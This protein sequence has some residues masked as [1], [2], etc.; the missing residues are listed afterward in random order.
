MKKI[1][2]R[3][4]KDTRGVVMMEYIVLGLFAV[5]VTVAT[6]MVLGQQYNKGLA[7]MGYAVVGET[8]ATAELVTEAKKSISLEVAADYASSFKDTGTSSTDDFNY[9]VYVNTTVE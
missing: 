3:F 4:I 1:F 5:S 2:A 7:A 6:V 8:S 9:D